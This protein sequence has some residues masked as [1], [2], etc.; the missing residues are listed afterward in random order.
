MPLTFVGY[1]EA[2]PG[3]PLPEEIKHSRETGVGPAPAMLEKIRQ[4]P[5]KLPSTCTLVGSWGVTGPGRAGVMVVEAESWADLAFINEYYRGWLLFDWHPT[6]SG[7][8]PRT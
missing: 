3:T 5:A 2:W 6:A 8:V 4:F 1:Y 7:G